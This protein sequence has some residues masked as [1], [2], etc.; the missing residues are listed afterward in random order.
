M[1]GCSATDLIELNTSGI[2]VIATW[3]HLCGRLCTIS[4]MHLAPRGGLG[5]MMVLII[6]MRIATV[7]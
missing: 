6:M 4:A 1:V 7:V 5:D 3:N 2:N